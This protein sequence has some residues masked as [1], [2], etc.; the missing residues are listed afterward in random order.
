MAA[1]N[2]RC[3]LDEPAATR[4]ADRVIGR[5]YICVNGFRFEVV[6]GSKISSP[7]AALV[8]ANART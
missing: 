4:L 3:Q 2:C 8:K 1:P 5:P 7:A 6:N